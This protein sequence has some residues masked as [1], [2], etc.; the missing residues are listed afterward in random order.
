MQRR[1]DLLSLTF[2]LTLLVPAFAQQQG[3]GES[4]PYGDVEVGEYEPWDE[5]EGGAIFLLSSNPSNIVPDPL[6]VG[7]ANVG[8]A[9]VC[10]A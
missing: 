7:S 8:S 1:I 2:I 10:S 5:G 6:S 9:K 4:Q 3:Q